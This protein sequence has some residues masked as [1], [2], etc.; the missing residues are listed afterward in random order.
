MKYLSSILLVI[1]A[2]SAAVAPGVQTVLAGH[3]VV[4]SVIYSVWGILNHFLPA[5]TQA[6]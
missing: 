5:P 3:P 1:S 2:V 4:V 6:K